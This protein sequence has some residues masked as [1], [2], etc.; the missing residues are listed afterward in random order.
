MNLKAI[1]IGGGCLSRSTTLALAAK[2][3]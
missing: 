3:H 2:R 1:E